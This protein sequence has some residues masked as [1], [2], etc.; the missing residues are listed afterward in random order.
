MIINSFS[1]YF[2]FLRT[3]PPRSIF[4]FFPHFFSAFYSNIWSSRKLIWQFAIFYMDV[5]H[6]FAVWNIDFIKYVLFK[7]EF[8]RNTHLS[9][10][11]KTRQQK[12]YKQSV[13]ILIEG[14]QTNDTTKR[15]SNFIISF[16]IHKHWPNVCLNYIC[17]VQKFWGFINF[18]KSFWIQ[19]NMPSNQSCFWVPHM[20]NMP[21]H[22]WFA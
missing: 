6:S 4:S 22:V 17:L 13:P 1:Y 21:Y 11:L 8:W 2:H 9:N 14:T 7:V 15:I 5:S 3:F 20:V 19:N 18:N 12:V 10:A 16:F